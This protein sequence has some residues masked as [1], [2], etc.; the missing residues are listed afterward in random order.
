MSFEKTRKNL[1][2]GDFWP[3]FA[4]FNALCACASRPDQ[5]SIQ[6]E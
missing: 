5:E 3:V 4:D 6:C 2:I 1:K